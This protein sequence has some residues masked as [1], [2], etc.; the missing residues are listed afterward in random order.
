MADGHLAVSFIVVSGWTITCFLPDVSL[1][2]DTPRILHVLVNNFIVPVCI[3][4]KCSTV[5]LFGGEG[6]KERTITA[7]KKKRSML[8]PLHW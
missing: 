5:N 4:S 8:L 6:K 3:L 2:E 1:N 7:K